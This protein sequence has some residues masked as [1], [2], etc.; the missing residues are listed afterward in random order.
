MIPRARI[1]SFG[2]TTLLLALAACHGSRQPWTVVSPTVTQSISQFR[3][4]GTLGTSI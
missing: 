3:L 1:R 4:T 2:L